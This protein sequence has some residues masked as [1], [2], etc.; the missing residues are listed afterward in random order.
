M[1]STEQNFDP[2]EGSAAADPL[3]W[4]LAMGLCNIL[5]AATILGC[6]LFVAIENG[7]FHL[8]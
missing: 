8:Y 3:G 5:I 6:I 7:M 4:T 2:E 1:K